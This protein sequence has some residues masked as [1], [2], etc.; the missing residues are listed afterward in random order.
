MKT[1]LSIRF[2]LTHEVLPS[3][4]KRI[5]KVIITEGIEKKTDGKWILLEGVKF[6]KKPYYN[7]GNK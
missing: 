5:I 7:E 2:S 1:T 3:D 4:L 6:V